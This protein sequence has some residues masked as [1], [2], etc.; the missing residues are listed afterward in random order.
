[1]LQLRS[2]NPGDAR[3]RPGFAALA[4]LWPL[5]AIGAGALLTLGWCLFL[6]WKAVGLIGLA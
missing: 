4:D 2:L 5:A 6:A 3:P 1:M